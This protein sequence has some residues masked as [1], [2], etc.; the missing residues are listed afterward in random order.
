MK[1]SSIL[2]FAIV[3]LTSMF[4]AH[5]AS[6]VPQMINYQGTLTDNTG[7]PVANGNYTIEF[8]LYDVASGGASLWSEKWET[9]NQIPVIDGNF[10]AMLG[11]VSPI[12]ATFFSDHPVVYLGIKVG[13]DSEMLPRQQI[14]SVGYAFT[15]GNGIPKGGIIMW[16]GAV[17]QIPAGWALCDGVERT[18]SDG[19][20][21]TPPDLRNKF[22]I[23][24]GS[25]YAVKE[26]G[27]AST[28]N[29]QHSHVVDGHSHVMTHTHT[30]SGTTGQSDYNRD[31]SSGS[32]S[33]AGDTH[34]H[35]F[36]G[37]TSNGS[38]G[39]TGLSAPGT[40]AQL[41]QTQS[42]LPPYFALAYIMKL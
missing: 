20:K 34:K 4:H 27:G 32:Y 8:R 40:S 23:G 39:E 19:S 26:T 35:T 1:R 28:I 22:I 33:T 9:P 3:L 18:L 15:A 2:L 36:S 6:A 5:G 10:N 21:I 13:S 12:P 25:S 41:G 24:A 7:N 38:T 30:Y 17:N 16:S 31:R 11:F 37:T 42:I 14:T 29:I